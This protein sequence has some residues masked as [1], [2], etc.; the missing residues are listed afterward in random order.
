MDH[1]VTVKD[2]LA[3]Y[4]KNTDRSG[5]DAGASRKKADKT[6]TDI[7]AS[8]QT[9]KNT[10]KHKQSGVKSGQIE[11]KQHKSIVSGKAAFVHRLGLM[12]TTLVMAACFIITIRQSDLT[13]LID[14]GRV[15]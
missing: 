12:I 6:L 8:E 3:V 2:V 15:T 4:G 5:T 13:R 14:D 9:E 7:E 11:D 10:G 1:A